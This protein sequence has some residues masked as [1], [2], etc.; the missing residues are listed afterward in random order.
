MGLPRA[1]A[2]RHTTSRHM[3]RRD[4]DTRVCLFFVA[5]FLC[6]LLVFRRAPIGDKGGQ[7]ARP[8]RTPTPCDLLP[9]RPRCKVR[10]KEAQSPFTQNGA[11]HGLSSRICFLPFTGANAGACLR[12]VKRSPLSTLNL[13]SHTDA[14]YTKSP[15]GRLHRPV[16][17]VAHI[18]SIRLLERLLGTCL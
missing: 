11:P 6:L 16:Q 1:N 9:P 4:V 10:C 5:C 7:R 17:P 12:M 8:M 3:C 15:L 18:G 2:V 13:V 14:L